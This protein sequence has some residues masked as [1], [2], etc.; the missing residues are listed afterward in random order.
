MRAV[1]PCD[2]RIP[3]FCA[4]KLPNTNLATGALGVGAGTVIGPEIGVTMGGEMGVTADGALGLGAGTAMGPEIGVTMGGETGVTADGATVGAPLGR[5]ANRLFQKFNRNRI[6]SRN[7]I[8]M[9]CDSPLHSD[10]PADDICRYL[11]DCCQ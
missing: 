7:D 6:N 4:V 3:S 10:K 2:N 5:G 9:L 11:I 1:R 8:L